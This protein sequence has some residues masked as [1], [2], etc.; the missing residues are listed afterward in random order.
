MNDCIRALCARLP[1]ERG[2]AVVELFDCGEALLGLEILIENLF[3]FELPVTSEE[4]TTL[5]ES[6]RAVGLS[7]HLLRQVLQSE[8]LPD[9]Q[10]DR[11]SPG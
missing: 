11:R 8:R 4:A 7:D 5:L 3:D 6:A 10:P 1:P 9:G 2:N